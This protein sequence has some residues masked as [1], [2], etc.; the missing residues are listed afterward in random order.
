MHWTHGGRYTED[1][2]D[3]G[4]H[5]Y[6][7]GNVGR[8]G[9]SASWS[10]FGFK[11]EGTADAHDHTHAEEQAYWSTVESDGRIGSDVDYMEYLAPSTCAE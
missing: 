4:V 10:N 9:G 1:S 2:W 5:A 6:L 3:F 7:G 8:G 11:F